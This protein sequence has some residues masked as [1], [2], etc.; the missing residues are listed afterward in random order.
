MALPF[1]FDVSL[2][3]SLSY[4]SS[5]CLLGLLVAYVGNI[6]HT[7]SLVCRVLEGSHF[8]HYDKFFFMCPSV[9]VN[10]KRQRS[11]GISA[12]MLRSLLLANYLSVVHE[13]QPDHGLLYW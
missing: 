6:A 4:S 7:C 2:L 12:S 13:R 8:W 9:F 3:F 10:V 5:C 1:L 11:L